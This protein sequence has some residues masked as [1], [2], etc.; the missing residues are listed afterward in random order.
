MW[1]LVGDDAWETL[2]VEPAG[3]PV[4]GTLPLHR[5]TP[6]RWTEVEVHG[7]DLGLGLSD[8]S[9]DFVTVALPMRLAWLNTRRTNHR[10]VDESVQG[11]W[12]LEPTGNELGLSASMG[13][14]SRRHQQSSLIVASPPEEVVPAVPR[15]DS[16]PTKVPRSAT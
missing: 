4:L 10:A 11:A 3:N 2:V 15:V 7:T 1:R 5:V 12:L 9:E 14:S 8:W 16:V 6:M 13:P